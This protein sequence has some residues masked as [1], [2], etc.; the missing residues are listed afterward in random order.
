MVV[1]TTAEKVAILGQEKG[2]ARDNSLSIARI[3][4]EDEDDIKEKYNKDSVIQLNSVVIFSMMKT[5]R[6]RSEKANDIQ[7]IFVEED[8][9]FKK[10]TVKMF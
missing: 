10:N 9:I 5:E 2:H 3:V 4:D 8:L 6:K 7:R 1:L